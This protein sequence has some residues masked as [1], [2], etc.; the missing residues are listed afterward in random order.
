MTKLEDER[1][2]KQQE[3]DAAVGRQRYIDRDLRQKAA[4]EGDLDAFQQLDSESRMLEAR[5]ES[6]QREFNALDKQ[7]FNEFRENA[8]KLIEKEYKRLPAA[9]AKVQK[10]D[11]ALRAAY[12]E[13]DEPLNAI[14]SIRAALRFYGTEL[15]AADKDAREAFAA[16]ESCCYRPGVVGIMS[17]RH[18]SKTMRELLGEQS[19]PAILRG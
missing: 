16:I 1:R 9:V 3:L 2:A 17:H 12:A 4:A 5:I 19:A 11:A 6:L 10:A 13:L 15:P 18:L 7:V 14:S 8:P